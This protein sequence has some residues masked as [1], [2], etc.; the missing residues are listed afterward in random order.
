MS[1]FTQ[2]AQGGVSRL[3]VF[4]GAGR[5]RSWSAELK[6]R[7]V[8]ESYAPG[9]SLSAVARRYAILPTQLFSWRRDARRALSVEPGTGFAAITV[10]GPDRVAVVEVEYGGAVV[11]VGPDVQVEQ[12]ATVFRALR[13]A[14]L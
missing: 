11:R 14:A 3:E 2:M 6:E 8:A 4:S 9:S 5:R 7:I 10:A 13:A 12:L 1:G